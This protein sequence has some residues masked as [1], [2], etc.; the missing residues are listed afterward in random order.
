MNPSIRETVVIDQLRRRNTN[1]RS[2][3][4][5]DIYSPSAVSM[6][7]IMRMSARAAAWHDAVA[8]KTRSDVLWTV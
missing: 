3:T 2:F 7:L 6:P 5:V 8:A 1:D 4:T